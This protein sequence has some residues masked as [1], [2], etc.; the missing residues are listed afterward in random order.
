MRRREL[1]V[2]ASLAL[3]LAS[4]LL[5]APPFQHDGARV[6]RPALRAHSPLLCDV[7]GGDDKKEPVPPPSAPPPLDVRE[8]FEA[9]RQFGKSIRDRFTAPRVDDPGLPYADALVCIC[10]ALFVAS[11]GLTGSIPRPS[12]LFALVPP[13]V[14][15]IR[16]IPYILPAFSHGVGLAS[17]W[18]LGAY[19]A[20]AFEADAYTG[21]LRE[22]VSRTWK[23][24]A[25][26]TGC[27]LLASQA[28]AA[29]VLALQGVD[30]LAASTEADRVTITTAFEVIT[31][32]LVQAGALT[33]FRVYRWADAQQY[34]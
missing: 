2:G 12:W 27:L 33:A 4:G 11:L 19:A 8:E 14:E 32:V 29:F 34:K 30:P 20:N 17:C 24:G 10:G 9:G 18:I 16:G 26:A 28:N 15:P 25:F 7:P 21:T 6:Q 13:G 1:L 5:H 23:A 3:P 22:A 31:D